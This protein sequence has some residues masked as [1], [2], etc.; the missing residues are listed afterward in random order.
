M[1]GL[2]RAE[3]IKLTTTK[4]A[5]GLVVGG[6]AVA[7][8]GAFSTIMSASTEDLAR[9][10]HDQHFFM[11]AS[12]N[13]ALFALVLGIRSVTDEFRHGS[14]VPTLLVA[15]KRSRVVVAKV[16]MSGAAGAAMSAVAQTA[17]LALAVPLI[18]AKGS[19]PSFEAADLAAVGGLVVA[20][21]LWAAIGAAVGAIVRYQVAAVVGALV[22]VLVLENL[23]S[24]F[25]GDA[26]RF[27]PG[28]A[29]HAVAQATQAGS[30]LAPATGAVVRVAYVL[31]ASAAAALR[32]TRSDI[33]LT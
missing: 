33:A 30:L 1:P 7:A 6:S 20:G 9:P 11:L 19:G 27:L 14:I 17:M 29:A 23:G 31:A 32:T 13:L 3:L 2:V 12:I 25:L 15:P 18:A 26:G 22:W 24:V 8:L 5:L 4:T 16:A 28:Q 21:A 10:V